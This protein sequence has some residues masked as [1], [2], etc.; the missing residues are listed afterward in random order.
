[1]HCL[2]T[3][4]RLNEHFVRK[5]LEDMIFE[6]FPENTCPLCSIQKAKKVYPGNTQKDNFHSN[7]NQ[8][9]KGVKN[10][11]SNNQN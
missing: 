1:M 9:L 4:Q 5:R 6:S 3:I 7:Q 11:K 8:E 10:E 2:E